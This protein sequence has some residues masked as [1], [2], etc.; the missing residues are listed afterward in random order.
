M[1]R[2]VYPFLLL[3]C[4]FLAVGAWL[5]LTYTKAQ[6]LLAVNGHYYPLGDAV[7]PYWTDWGDGAAAIG[8]VIA[9]IV[10]ARIRYGF[11][12]GVRYGV[13]GGLVFAIPSLLS[14][15]I[16]TRF[17]NN[18]PRPATYFAATPQVLHHIEGVH[19][20][21]VDSFP[22]GHTITA[23]S[24]ALLLIYLLAGKGRWGW[25][26]GLFVWACSVGY[27]RMYLAQHFFRDVYWG[28]VIGVVS[29]LGTIWLGEWILRQF[30]PKKVRPQG[31][32]GR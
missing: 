14:L 28:A 31:V 21:L 26:A 5:L 13:L 25:S 19:L 23:F 8:I 30:P 12:Q 4:V 22:S 17:F 10:F 15:L 11:A 29:G 9:L 24:M 2:R 20:W 18:E 7:M 3:F 1:I 6:L 27:S 32:T 16:K